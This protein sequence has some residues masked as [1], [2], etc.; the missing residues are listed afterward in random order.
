MK[1]LIIAFIITSF[2]L[3]ACQNTNQEMTNE[4]NNVIKNGIRWQGN[5]ETANHMAMIGLDRYITYENH[6]AFIMSEAAVRK[7]PSLFASHVI[8]A[9][10]AEGTRKTYHKKMANKFVENENETGKLFVSLLNFDDSNDSTRKE[11]KNIWTKMHQLSNDPFIYYM[12]IRFMDGTNSEKIAELK[13]LI[14]FCKEN[15][16]N[17]TATAANNMMAYLLKRE[18]DL[19]A[20]INAIDEC[21]NFHPEG[22]NPLDSRAEF[23]LYEGDT[24]NAIQTYKKVLEK[25]PYAS[26]SKEQLAKLE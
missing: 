2:F 23:Y 20:G 16:F 6:H 4:N 24:V 13:N 21:I 19:D 9:F 14:D 25:Y 15:N 26:Y 1:Y 3:A 11:R 17:Y 18:G 7:D 22:Y 5:D 8:L 12:Y 10:L